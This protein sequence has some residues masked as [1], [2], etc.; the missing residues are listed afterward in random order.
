M[1][2]RVN[3]ESYIDLYLR[4][5]L[6]VEMLLKRERD[7]QEIKIK[8]LLSRMGKPLRKTASVPTSIGHVSSSVISSQVL[9]SSSP[10]LTSFRHNSKLQVIFIIVF[11]VINVPYLPK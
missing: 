4:N 5:V 7:R 9:F 8:D 6:S 10:N 11:F 1:D 2:G 3:G